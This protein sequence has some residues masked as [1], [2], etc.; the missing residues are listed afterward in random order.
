MRPVLRQDRVDGDDGDAR[1]GRLFHGG[2]DPVH[3]DGHDGKAIHALLD[4]GLDRA[5][6]RG[7]VVVGV[8]D[9]EVHAGR[10]GGGLRAFV[11][12]V[13]EQRLLVDLDQREGLFL[14]GGRDRCEKGGGGQERGEGAA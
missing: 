4:V 3:V 1:G 8:E 9:H 10:I 13:E 11:H 6:L 12:L 7:G 5:V 2:H 14:R